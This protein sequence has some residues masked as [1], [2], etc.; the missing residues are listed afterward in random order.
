MSKEVPTQPTQ[1]MLAVAIGRLEEKLDGIDQKVD[2]LNTRLYGNGKPGLI[3][4]QDR[5]AA[6]V[7][8][9]IKIAQ[10]N[11]TNIINLQKETPGRW[12]VRNW[13]SIGLIIVFGFVILHSLIP[14][15]L[16]VWTWISSL[17]GGPK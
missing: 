3:I 8:D 17:F 13:K 7:A 16:S 1:E 4:D 10:A 9:L 11:A 2:S 14:A 15:N 6:Q 5:L 12:I